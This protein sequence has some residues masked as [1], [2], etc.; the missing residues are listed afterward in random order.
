[1][2]AIYALDDEH[3]TDRSMC[4]CFDPWNKEVT[5]ELAS[6]FWP[7]HITKLHNVVLLYTLY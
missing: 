7:I 3:L 5:S 1:M 4:F 6:R 2:T